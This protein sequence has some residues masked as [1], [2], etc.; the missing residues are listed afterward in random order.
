MKAF[1]SRWFHV[2]I[3]WLFAS[4]VLADDERHYSPAVG[5]DFPSKV[6]WGYSHLHTNLSLDAAAGGNRRFCHDQSYRLA[7]GE[8][9]TA[10]NGMRVRLNRPLDFLLIADS[11]VFQAAALVPNSQ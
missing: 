4:V 11:L 3:L 8:V 7:R 5:K 10:H 2:G 6:F 9:V 1:R